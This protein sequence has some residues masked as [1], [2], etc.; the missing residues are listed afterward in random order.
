MGHM[1]FRGCELFFF[2]YSYTNNHVRVC[3]AAATLIQRDR[4]SIEYL[5]IK[6]STAPS[7]V[8]VAVMAESRARVLCSEQ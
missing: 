5:A 2:R 6:S 3:D 7:V 8:I 4:L 1:L